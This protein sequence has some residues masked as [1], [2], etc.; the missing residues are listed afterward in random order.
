MSCLQRQGRIIDGH[1]DGIEDGFFE[2]GE[3]RVFCHRESS[4]LKETGAEIAHGF[5]ALRIRGGHADPCGTLRSTVFGFHL[6]E[7]SI[8]RSR[9]LENARAWAA[10]GFG[11]HLNDPSRQDRARF[12]LDGGGFGA[13]RVRAESIDGAHPTIFGFGEDESAALL[14]ECHQGCPNRVAFGG[15]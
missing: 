1:G 2:A 9:E 14:I 12:E 13:R 15:P 11:I 4:R 6:D 8:N 5:R 7:S 10:L 3:F